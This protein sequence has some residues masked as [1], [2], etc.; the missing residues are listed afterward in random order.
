MKLPL[1]WIVAAFAAGV[2]I[3]KW[4][5]GPLRLWVAAALV[6]LAAT[7]LFIWWRRLA[8]AWALALVAWLAIGV[9]AL[10]VERAAIPSNHVTRLIAAGRLDTNEP[11]RWQGRLRED[12]MTLPWGRRYEMNLEQVEIAGRL[13]ADQR[14]HASESVRRTGRTQRGR[15]ASKSSRGRSRGG[16]G[17]SAAAAKFRRSRRVRP[18]RLS[19][20]PKNR[21]D[22]V[23]SQ[24]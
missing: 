3:G 14:R 12:P 6:A 23:P 17:K 9:V 2:E 8:A 1:V 16:A 18:P 5:P 15:R 4:L 10:G 19:R 20:R 22:C 7:A 24:R 11:L 13:F 21:F